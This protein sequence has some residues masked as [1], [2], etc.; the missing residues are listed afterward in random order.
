[1]SAD[2]YTVYTRSRSDDLEN[3]LTLTSFLNEA[4]ALT[5]ESESS[6]YLHSIHFTLHKHVRNFT[7]E[8]VALIERLYTDDYAGIRRDGAK[9]LAARAAWC[10]HQNT[11]EGKSNASEAVMAL[12][13]LLLSFVY[14]QEVTLTNR[15]VRIWGLEDAIRY[16]TPAFSLVLIK[17][18]YHEERHY[19]ETRLLESRLL[20]PV[21]DRW[22][23]CGTHNIRH[24]AVL[25]TADRAALL[26]LHTP[27][28]DAALVS[29]ADAPEE[30]GWRLFRRYSC[31]ARRLRRIA[32]PAPSLVEYW[33]K[34]ANINALRGLCWT[35]HRVEPML[36]R[37]V[38]EFVL[39]EHIREPLRDVS[40]GEQVQVAY[41]LYTTLGAGSAR[42][43]LRNGSDATYQGVALAWRENLDNDIFELV[44]CHKKKTVREWLLSGCAGLYRFKKVSAHFRQRLLHDFLPTFSNDRAPSIREYA[45]AYRE[46]LEGGDWKAAAQSPASYGLTHKLEAE[47]TTPELANE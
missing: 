40:V 41:M 34:T 16:M 25:T 38:A 35:A 44:R 21:P 28:V 23:T 22:D 29:R 2:W 17:E 42:A 3:P 19:N 26:D 14:E 4:C 9:I 39:Q 1:M 12:E 5:K 13:R 30:I 31:D 18:Y 36:Q 33:L 24:A 8:H 46:F 45:K 43:L 37:R 10:A 6:S 15:D 20:L 32:H 7:P 27:A 11:S 47:Y